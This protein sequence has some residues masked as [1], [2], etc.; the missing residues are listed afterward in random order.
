[1]KLGVAITV[2]LSFLVG[3]EYTR[4]V[5][6]NTLASNLTYNNFW[7]SVGGKPRELQ[8]VQER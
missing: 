8:T 4:T 3:G 2:I 1:M 6:I 7:V 5:L